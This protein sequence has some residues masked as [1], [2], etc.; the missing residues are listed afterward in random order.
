M[1]TAPKQAGDYIQALNPRGYL[2]N[3]EIT[4]LD[5]QYLVKGSQNCE[6]VNQEKVS[7]VPGFTL[8]GSA[9]TKAAGHRSSHDWETNTNAHRSLRLNNDGE[10]EVY[11]K[12]D[13]HLL[14]QYYP[15]TRAE[16][17]PWWSQT[18]LKDLLLFVVGGSTVEMWSGGIA[19]IASST[20]TTLTLKRYVSGT[21]Y[22]FYD[23]GGVTPS[24]IT[25][26]SNGFLDA[27]FTVGDKFV[28]QG[29]ASNDGIYTISAVTAGVITIFPD[30]AFTVEAS[31]ASVVIKA[32]GATWGESR[33][34][35]AGTRKVR[36]NGVEYAYSGGEG[37]GTLTGLSGVSGVSPGDIALQAVVTNSPS[38]FTG[39]HIDLISVTE[40]YVLY[41][42]KTDRRYFLSRSS[43]YTSFTSSELRKPGEGFKGAFDSAPTAF[44]PDEGMMYIFGRRDDA[45]KLTFTLSSDFSAEA[46]KV[47]KGK[48]ATG[49]AAISQGSCVA[50]K[51]AIAFISFEPTI[52]TIGNVAFFNAPQAVPL[53]DPI[54][55]DIEAYDTTDAHGIYFRR[56]AYWTLPNEGLFITYNTQY[57]HWQPPRLAAI[58]RFALI[59]IEGDG[60][61]V[62]CGHSSVGN[63]TYQLLTGYS[64]NGARKK[65]VAALGYDNYGARFVQKSA[66]EFASELYMSTNTTVQHTVV[67]DYKGATDVRTF[68][69]RGDDNAIS[70]VPTT[71]GG[72]GDDPL[73]NKPF[74]SL[75]DAPDDMH[76]VRCVDTTPVVDFFEVQRVYTAEGEDARFSLIAT[77]CNV[78]MSDNIPAFIK[79]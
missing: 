47:E 65:V 21:T 31:G 44:V 74:G 5:G 2:N 35:T 69:I 28:V 8:L 59:D 63:E 51:N 73:G 48:T 1:A 56:N 62:L 11:W 72:L 42:S 20:A 34:L 78:E 70:F 26:S 25:D 38:D 18:E 75:L 24:T 22:T 9:K 54:K 71:G 57:N 68:D 27:G 79:R 3:R 39:L 12:H 50:I 49:Q 55:N 30:Q 77:G 29:S 13:W 46:I 33:F 14:K 52:D 7:S 15:L 64:D 32:P 66:D 43:D 61:L 53:S 4:N 45:Y 41:G 16:F 37:T 67:Y 36:V 40:N 60:N 58:G 23:D 76:K 6:I 19:E 17:Y 10:L